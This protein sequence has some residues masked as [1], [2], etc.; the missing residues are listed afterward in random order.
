MITKNKIVWLVYWMD[1][2]TYKTYGVEVTNDEAVDAW[3]AIKLGTIK[4]KDMGCKIK[5]D[6]EVDA[7]ILKING[8]DFEHIADF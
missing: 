6:Y 2:K 7:K 3:N 5:K 4:L 8:E 1:K